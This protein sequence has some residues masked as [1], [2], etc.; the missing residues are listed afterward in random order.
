MGED[1]FIDRKQGTIPIVFDKSHLLTIG[2]RLYSTSLD[3]IRELVSNAYDAD[4]TEVAIEITP[5]RIVVA[6]NGGGMS[7]SD[8]RRYFTIGTRGKRL[9]PTSPRFGRERIGEFGIGKFSALTVAR[10]FIVDTRQIEGTFRARVVFDADQWERDQINWHLPYEILAPLPGRGSGTTITLNKLKKPLEVSHVMRHVRERLPIGRPDFSVSVNGFDIQPTPI[11]GRHFP[12][13]FDTPFGRVHGDIILANLPPSRR[14]LADAGITI[15]VKGVAVMQS[16]FGF[17]QSRA[18]GISRLRGVLHAD[19]L[20]ITSSRDNVI[21]DAPEFLAVYEGMQSEIRKVLKQARELA[22]GRENLQASRA[23]K[24]A[25]DRIGRA[26]KRN[27]GAFSEPP[28]DLPVGSESGEIPGTTGGQEGYSI[29]KAQFVDVGAPTPGTGDGN[30]KEEHEG[31]RPLGRK[32]HIGLANRAIIRTMQF[33]NLGLVCRMER[34]GE[35]CPPSFFEQG[36]I[37]VNI[38]HPL[39]RKQMDNESLLH[40]FLT[41]LISKEL[42]LQKYAHDAHE[43]FRLQHELL[44]DAFRHVKKL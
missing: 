4:A 11:S 39:Y 6:D 32:R 38:D 22:L 9:S 36:I 26:L 21:T 31:E 8:L 30:E 37:Y 34:F 42:S 20:P 12:F 18:L 41:S 15:R 25:L 24:E 5:E 44:T 1:N 40:V 16:P 13:A 14:T 35:D 10:Q 33:R 28:V 43:A 19:F 29:S 27:P 3:L 17:E 23:L 7:E 2:E